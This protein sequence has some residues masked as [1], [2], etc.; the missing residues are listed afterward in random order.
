MK[1]IVARGLVLALLVF[2][3]ANALLAHPTKD[4]LTCFVSAMCASLRGFGQG[5]F[6]DSVSYYLFAPENI[7]ANR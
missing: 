7:V 2:T 1:G 6:R 4:P 3:P 5:V